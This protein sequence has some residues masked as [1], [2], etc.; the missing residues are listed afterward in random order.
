MCWWCVNCLCGVDV[1]MFVL[2]MIWIIVQ[3]NFDNW[4]GYFVIGLRMICVYVKLCYFG[5]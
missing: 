2:V 4:K 3:I 1:F 5:I